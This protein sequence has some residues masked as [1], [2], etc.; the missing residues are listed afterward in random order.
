M[1]NIGK[2]AT[3]V[4]YMK[5]KMN[6][7]CNTFVF[8]FIRQEIMHQRIQQKYWNITGFTVDGCRQDIVL[9]MVHLLYRLMLPVFIFLWVPSYVGVE[10]DGK[11]VIKITGSRYTVQV[12]LSGGRNSYN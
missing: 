2:A 11:T 1:N 5:I 4:F 3:F 7:L 12:P 8:Y 10:D 6:L 9:E